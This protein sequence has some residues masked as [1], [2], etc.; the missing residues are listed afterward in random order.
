MEASLKRACADHDLRAIGANIF[1]ACDGIITVYVHW[2]DGGCAS[3][4]GKTFDKALACA[5]SEMSERRSPIRCS[6]CD[7]TGDLRK[8]HDT[9]GHTPQDYVCASCFTPDTDGPA[10]DDLAKAEV[11]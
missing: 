11:A 7:A 4:S 3:G 5:I 9:G 8:H 6:Y 1:N 10:F 2:S